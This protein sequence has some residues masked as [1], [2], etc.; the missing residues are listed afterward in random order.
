GVYMLGLANEPGGYLGED[1]ALAV[2]FAGFV[3][4]VVSHVHAIAPELACTVVFAGPSDAAIPTLMPLLDVASFN[5]YAYD[6][7]ESSTCQV[8]GVNL[9][10]YEAS[11]GDGVGPLLDQMIEAA[12][13]RLICVQEFGQATGWGDM[14]L[15][16]GANAGLDNQKAIMDAVVEALD[17]R[18]AHFRT[19]CLWTLNDHSMEGIAYVGDALEAEGFPS[20]FAD[21]AEEIFGPTGIVR[22]DETAS[23]KPA[24]DAFKQGVTFFAAGA[25]PVPGMSLWGGIVLMLGMSACGTFLLCYWSPRS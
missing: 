14:P 18:R 21:N 4:Q 25:E 3:E 8:E 11:T 10:L 6:F 9:P 16:L 23:K 17:E 19:F 24:F 12:D 20:C 2:G 15:T 7:V 1:P 13:G 5:G 22:S